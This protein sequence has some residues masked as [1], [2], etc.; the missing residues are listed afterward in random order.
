MNSELELKYY[1]TAFGRMK[2]KIAAMP[3]APVTIVR[4][5]AYV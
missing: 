3:K 1:D 4:S 5:G 2:S